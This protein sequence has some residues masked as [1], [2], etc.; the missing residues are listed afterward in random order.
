MRALK[1]EQRANGLGLQLGK[2][3]E[4]PDIKGIQFQWPK[5]GPKSAGVADEYVA[6]WL[7]LSREVLASHKLSAETARLIASHT[8]RRDGGMRLSNEALASRSARS[9]ASVKRDIARLKQL[10]LIVVEHGWNERE[11]L[12]ARVI[13][14]AVCDT[15]QKAQRIPP[16][17]MGTKGS[18]YHLYVEPT[19]VGVC[20]HVE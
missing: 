17:N 16:I 4:L 8:S 18:T 5:S 20:R 13:F 10:G 15:G 12:R 11:K 2:K 14:L 6:D 19:D 1:F 7:Q 9:L 3:R